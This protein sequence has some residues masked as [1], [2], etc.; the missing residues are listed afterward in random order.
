VELEAFY[1]Q[2]LETIGLTPLD[3]ESRTVIMGL[4]REDRCIFVSVWENVLV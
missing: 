1:E 3:L 2:L 4:L